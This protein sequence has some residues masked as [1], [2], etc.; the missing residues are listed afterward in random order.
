MS[1]SD[2]SCSEPAQALA[3]RLG[4]AYEAQQGE[5]LPDCSFFHCNTQLVLFGITSNTLAL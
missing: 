2:W 5:L 3:F 4:V 1:T